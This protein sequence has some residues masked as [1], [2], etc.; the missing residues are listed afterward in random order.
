MSEGP[1]IDDYRGEFWRQAK[2]ASND[3]HLARLVRPLDQEVGMYRYR[4]RTEDGDEL[5]EATYAEWI[6]PGEMIH[7]AAG[8]R[9]RVLDVVPVEEEDSPFVG[10]LKVE[11]AA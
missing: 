10:F 6:N 11:P 4:L 3:L 7:F 9:L 1:S 8:K 5:G 2:V